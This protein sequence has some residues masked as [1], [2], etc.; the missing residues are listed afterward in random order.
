MAE[1]NNEREENTGRENGGTKR[2]MGEENQ[3][4]IGG[5]ENE[6]K[7]G[8]I[9]DRETK[10]GGMIKEQ[11]ES[12]KDEKGTIEKGERNKDNGRLVGSQRSKEE[13]MEKY[14]L[15]EQYNRDIREG[16]EYE[17]YESIRAPQDVN[18]RDW[19]QRRNYEGEEEW[20]R[21][22]YTEH[23]KRGWLYEWKGVSPIRVGPG[24]YGIEKPRWAEK[25]HQLLMRFEEGVLD[26][27]RRRNAYFDNHNYV[28]TYNYPQDHGK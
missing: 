6:T 26:Y 2:E 13:D 25:Y 3:D 20:K 7:K 11:M 14:Y 17:R 10:G 23:L 12:R 24:S 19:C 1:A 18:D 21:R 9:N 22:V 15:S 8:V 27:E 16:H 28:D 5:K 4:I